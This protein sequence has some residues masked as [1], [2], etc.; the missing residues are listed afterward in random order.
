MLVHIANGDVKDPELVTMLRRIKG[1]PIDK[2]GQKIRPAGSACAFMHVSSGVIMRSAAERVRT[3]IGWGNLGAGISGA[4]EALARYIQ[5]Y[6]ELN[7]SHVVIKLDWKNAFNAVRRSA[8]LRAAES[9][10]DVQAIAT[11]HLGGN[12][13][14]TYADG[15][16]RTFDIPVKTGGLQGD[17]KMSFLFSKALNDVIACIRA[18]LAA[19]DNPQTRSVIIVCYADDTYILG[20]VVQASATVTRV[21][22][23]VRQELDLEAQPS[24]SEAYVSGGAT[25]EDL[26]SLRAVGIPYSNGVM[27]TGTPV[28]T[29]EYVE[30][31]LEH[32][33]SD[34]MRLAQE[35]RSLRDA[36]RDPKFG[37][38]VSTQGLFALVRL[39]V[40]STFSY[41]LRTVYPSVIAPYAKRV[42]DVVTKLALDVI[43]FH[44]L[45]TADF[46]ES[47]KGQIVTRR[48]FLAIPRGG[49]GLFSCVDNMQ[50][51]YVGSAA[52]TCSLLRDLGVDPA[53]E[54]AA[55]CAHVQELGDAI[56][57]LRTR[58]PKCDEIAQWTIASI[59][60]QSQP[61]RQRFVSARL[62]EASAAHIRT[63]F[64]ETS[65]GRR[66]LVEFAECGAP[67]AGA[68]LAVRSLD[69]M[70]TLTN[71]EY[72][73]ASAFRLGITE[74][75][76]PHVPPSAVC[77]GCKHPIGPDVARHALSCSKQGRRGRHI[78]H[79]ALKYA[80]QA[81]EARSEAGTWVLN[82]P[83]VAAC[84]DIRPS[85]DEYR[86]SR[87]DAFVRT[88]S[89]ANYV[90]DVT[91]VN[92]ASDYEH[93]NITFKA[94]EETE[95]AFKDKVAQYSE[96]R[97][98]TMDAKAN[99]RIAA[100]DV[101]GGAS[102]GTL[103]YLREII[104]RESSKC[105]G[106]THKSIIASRLYQRVS[107]AI[108]KSVAYNILEYRYW[109]VP[110]RVPTVQLPVAAPLAAPQYW[111]LGVGDG[112]LGHGGRT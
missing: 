54:A 102:K 20:P 8:L 58:L 39:C 63:L 32:R 77:K 103:D 81:L 36:A 29:R 110:V 112:H 30:R 79:T 78:R 111:Q 44:D 52:L 50:A 35:I 99:L 96:E 89:G 28:G 84:L 105:E 94:G 14:V 6:S 82:E 65:E 106:L 7:P 31:F 22:Q 61:E 49:M 98:P 95:Q 67:K 59:L 47:T 3:A 90:V 24:K 9:V 76:Y 21:S 51:A 19:S 97:F 10:T 16:G 37:E 38:P 108:Q 55:T 66:D 87:G 25:Q 27:A 15:H 33:V 100:F 45:T 40:P 5:L 46:L 107:V 109:R 4:T 92:A 104:D 86:G 74:Q 73:I 13:T 43:G 93:A 48:L 53:T 101:R 88:P 18:K 57:A 70:S 60:K 17:P 42:D 85:K 80:I 69:K 12:A 83:N 64:P 1:H 91:I 75:L 62:A 26:E 71:G 11:L 41:L 23:V 2:G 34:L 68:W 72:W 56:T